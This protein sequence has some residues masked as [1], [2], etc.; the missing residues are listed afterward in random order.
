[1]ETAPTMPKTNHTQPAANAKIIAELF[2][3]SSEIPGTAPLELSQQQMQT[4]LHIA[5]VTT[6][7][8][9]GPPNRYLAGV[10]DP[11][12]PAKIV[13]PLPCLLFA[14]LLMFLRS[15]GG[16]SPDRAQIPRQSA[17]R[18]QLRA[19]VRC[20]ECAARRYA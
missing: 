20:R 2:P 7:H 3:L 1:M 8:F 15:F 10:E 17:L 12:N 6:T 9:F 5:L 18:S 19:T 16:A 14:G 4:L 11:R 13:Y